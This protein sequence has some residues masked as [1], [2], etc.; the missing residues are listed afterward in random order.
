MAEAAAGDPPPESDPLGNAER[1]R[2]AAPVFARLLDHLMGQ[3]PNAHRRL[4]AHAGRRVR[5]GLQDRSGRPIDWLCQ[6]LEFDA[7]GH[8]RAAAPGA[9]DAEIYLFADTRALGALRAGRPR[10]LLDALRLEGDPLLAGLVGEILADLRWDAEDDLAA[11]LGD[12]PARRLS[13]WFTQGRAALLDTG[14]RAGD[15]ARRL[16]ARMVDASGMMAPRA[17][18]ESLDAVL[19]DLAERLDALERRMD[20]C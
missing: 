9:A 11:L 18:V 8:P 10:E 2:L 1:R 12:L 19:R 5:L 15:Q 20:R 7:G 14:R 13:V 3:H 16:S 6:T 17:G 4:A